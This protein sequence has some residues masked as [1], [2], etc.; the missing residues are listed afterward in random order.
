MR[1][2]RPL[3]LMILSSALFVGPAHAGLD[4]C[5]ES[6]G[7]IAGKFAHRRAKQFARCN[8]AGDCDSAASIAKAA[9]LRA[10]SKRT[11]SADCSGLDGPALG[12]GATCPDPSG[13]CTMTLDADAAL[14]ECILC[15]VEETIEP[16]IRRLQGDEA[17][18]A[19][20]C[21]GCA[22]TPCLE[23]FV[24][25]TPPGHCDGDTTVGTCIEVPGAC[26]E[27]F[28]P[29]CGCDGTTYSNDCVRR[30]NR[31]AL[32]HPGPCQTFCGDATGDT[33]PDGTFC[34][35]LPGHCEAAGEG[36][37]RPVPA[38]CPDGFE[39]VCGC[40]G[41][42]YGND[43]E[44]QAAGI[45][46]QHFGP[47]DAL[48]GLD[49][50]GELGGCPDGQYCEHPPGLCLLAGLGGSPTIPGVC[51]PIPHACP[52]MFDP[53]CGCDGVTYSNDCVRM[54]AGVSKLHHGECESPCGGFAGFPCDGG[55][56]CDLPPGLCQVAD[57]QGH[58]V[59]RP[60][61]CPA[62]VD[63]VCGC[64]GVTYGNDCERLRA[65]AQ[66]AHFGPCPVT[67]ELHAP[68]CE[69][70]SVCVTPTG[71]CNDGG[72]GICVPLPEQ[73]N[74]PDGDPVCGCD[75]ATHDSACSALQAGVGIAHPGA[76][77]SGGECTSDADCEPDLRCVPLP[78]LCGVP[79]P[80]AVCLPL[81]LESCLLDFAV[82]CGCDGRTYDSLCAAADAGVGMLH[83]GP[84][85]DDACDEA[86]GG[87]APAAS[88]AAKDRQQPTR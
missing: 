1:S 30:Q 2:A 48:C 26:P 52:D 65:G 38:T 74:D 21:G 83:P 47:C 41:V 82:V 19:E 24:C 6:S 72:V 50:A 58:C 75:A 64:D 15:M 67:C 12:L 5:R 28:E 63:Q 85:P 22:A 80:L 35:G 3:A 60:E 20:S 4:D 77:G 42:T 33:C 46:L 61:A 81:D 51:L 45:R 40:D 34:D 78:G 84:C 68:E 62:V 87:C 44:R 10:R 29:V 79:D 16:L 32:F 25:E 86:T 57:L 73:C 8:L 88:D 31:A 7:Q 54:A 53:V 13:R 66:L 43:C 9:R 11:L 49:P 39:P 23:G 55:E 70:G 71:D 59:E 36:I 14:V 18:L 17:D 37:C 76:C 69:E 27:I 56:V